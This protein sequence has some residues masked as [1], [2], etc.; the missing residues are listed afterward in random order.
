[1]EKNTE[2]LIENSGKRLQKEIFSLRERRNKYKGPVSRKNKSKMKFLNKVRCS[3][4]PYEYVQYIVLE[5]QYF[6]FNIYFIKQ[7]RKNETYNRNQTRNSFITWNYLKDI[8]SYITSLSSESE[9]RIR[10]TATGV[11]RQQAF[12]ISPKDPCRRRK[13]ISETTLLNELIVIITKR[14]NEKK[15]LTLNYFST[16]IGREIY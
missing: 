7:R 10:L 9:G 8:E 15:G 6:S 5:V 2:K 12:K 11:P 16:H 13:F 1:M 4:V 3:V 14:S